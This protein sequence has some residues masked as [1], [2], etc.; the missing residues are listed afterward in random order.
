MK[1]GATMLPPASIAGRQ[2]GL[3]REHCGDPPALDQHSR[4]S[5]GQLDVVAFASFLGAVVTLSWL[6]GGPLLS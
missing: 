1:P 4:A 5:G 6:I 2:I 3:C